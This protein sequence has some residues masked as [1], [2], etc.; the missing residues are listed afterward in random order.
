ME[1]IH[2]FFRKT[3]KHSNG[4]YVYTLRVGVY[5]TGSDLNARAG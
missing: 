1:P 4:F 3:R 2:E 5:V